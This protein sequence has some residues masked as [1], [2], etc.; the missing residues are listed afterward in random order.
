MRD[1][2]RRDPD[3]SDLAQY[4]ETWKL[5]DHN[6]TARSLLLTVDDYFL[7]LDGLL[8]HLWTPKDRR[9]STTYQQL[10]IPTAL[11]YELLIWAHDDPTGGHFRTV[12]TYEKL[13]TR[14]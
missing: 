9:R 1:L 14:Y 6:D 2:Q 4:L 12:K 5:P 3:L 7:N 13:R 10:V 11:R 8:F